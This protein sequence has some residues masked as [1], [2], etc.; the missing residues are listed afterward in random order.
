M[1]HATQEIQYFILVISFY[2]TKEDTFAKCIQLK[3]Y[4]IVVLTLIPRSF[5]S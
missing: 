2:E 3:S 5:L 1:I 4:F